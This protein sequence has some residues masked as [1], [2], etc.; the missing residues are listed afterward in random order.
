MNFSALITSPDFE[1]FL[2]TVQQKYK[3]PD[4]LPERYK[5]HITFLFY[6]NHPFNNPEAFK[7]DIQQQLLQLTHQERTI[8]F[9]SVEVWSTR[10][11]RILVAK[12]ICSDALRDLR[13]KIYT[14]YN[15]QDS[16]QEY[17]PHVTLGKIKTNFKYDT[18]SIPP[19]Q[20]TIS[21]ILFK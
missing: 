1:P 12:V 13:N 21:D 14:Q 18:T 3:H 19:N 15:I 8:S 2:R 10:R 17:N 11:G 4:F 6:K 5:L 16:I 7:Q 20:F 9:G